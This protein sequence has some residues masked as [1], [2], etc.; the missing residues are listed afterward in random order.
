MLIGLPIGLIWRARQGVQH[1]KRGYYEARIEGMT[2]AEAEAVETREP[3]LFFKLWPVPVVIALVI[4][5]I[6][7]PVVSPVVI[8]IWL[9]RAPSPKKTE[10]KIRDEYRSLRP[11]R[12]LETDPR[13]SARERDRGRPD[14]E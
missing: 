2:D 4:L 12:I 8:V 14:A 5:C 1:F 7:V 9:A 10:R 11:H 3:S 6:A 13:E